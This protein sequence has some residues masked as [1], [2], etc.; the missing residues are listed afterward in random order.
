MLTQSERASADEIDGI[1][2]GRPC[3]RR[4]EIA[5]LVS[6]TIRMRGTSFGA[7]GV[8]LG[9]N[10]FGRRWRL[11]QRVEPGERFAQAPGEHRSERAPGAP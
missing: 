11:V 8:D 1:R 4:P 7:R 9:L 3:Q 6:T 10:L 5:V 2:R